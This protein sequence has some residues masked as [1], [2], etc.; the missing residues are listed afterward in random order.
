MESVTLDVE[1]MTCAACASRVEKSIRSVDGVAT[2]AVNLASGKATVSY[3]PGL[4]TV[5]QV[6]SAVEEVGYAVPR[7]REK[8][9]LGVTGMSCASCAMRIETALNGLDGVESATVNLAS[10]KAVIDYSPDIVKADDL[11]SAIRGAGYDVEDIKQRKTRSEIDPVEEDARRLADARNR[12]TWVWF[13]TAPIIIWMVPEMISGVKWPNDTIFDLGMLVLAGPVLFWKGWPTL[14]SAY[15]SARKLVPNMDVLIGMGT[16]T[17]FS[18][19]FVTLL[20]DLGL[21]PRLLNYAGVSAMIM[22]FHLTGRYI[23]SKAKGRASQAIQRL[24]TL[25]V[26]TARIR[27]DGEEVEV[28]IEEVEVGD[29]MV[30]RPGEKIPTDGEVVDGESAVDESI[31]TGESMPVEKGKGDKVLGATINK[32]GLLVVRATGVGEETFL[33][34]VIRLVEEAQGSKVPIQEFADRVTAI[35]V[36]TVLVLA[37]LTLISWLLFPVFF[38]GIALSASR[39]IPWV[40]PSL[41][42]VSL[43]LFATIAVL[44]IACPCALG[45]ATPTALMVGSGLGAENGVLIRHGEAIQTMREVSTIVLDKTGTITM[46]KPGVTDVIPAEGTSEEDLLRLAASAES[47]SEHPVGEAIVKEASER[48]MDLLSLE[49]FEAIGGKGVRATVGGET[50]ILVGSPAFLE[51]NGISP[52][53]LSRQL[54]ECESKAKTVIVVGASKNL[55]G[56]IAVADRVKADSLSAISDLKTMGLEP[57]M[58][59]GDNEKT[60]RAIADSVGIDRVIANVLP[61]QKSEVIR[62]LQEEG[63]KVAMVGDG[64]NDAP[65]LKQA[66]VG[67]AIGTGTDIAIESADITLVRGELSAVVT[68]VKLSRATFTKIKQNLFWA[69]FY[70]GIAIPVAIFGLLHPVIAEAAMAFSSI[71]VVTNANR[72]K[73]AKIRR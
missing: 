71:N 50:E 29:L 40:D 13:L 19:G 53:V 3:E 62:K 23:E 56:I 55:K 24:L 17:A 31:A 6:I 48:D 30:I 54:E 37:L 61:D 46:G 63:K 7:R 39:F 41:G 27:R 28:A 59:T 70:N 32:Q 5:K 33:S 26:K 64:I 12:M 72:L 69:Y 60:A 20:H 45:L 9:L 51:E 49:G 10:E 73:R 21:A 1:G 11:I 8:V 15:R 67:I 34:Q 14:V 38:N 58:L 52:M 35:F 42:R 2:V 68:G 4:T 47:G 18:T 43:A 22:A 57:V 66:N 65:A 16:I 25:E 36:P 44:V